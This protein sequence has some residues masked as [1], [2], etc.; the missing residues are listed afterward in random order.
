MEP[1]GLWIGRCS[2]SNSLRDGRVA[3]AIDVEDVQPA[4]IEYGMWSINCEAAPA[5]IATLGARWPQI[6]IMITAGSH[7]FLWSRAKAI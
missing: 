3:R 2:A 4:T 7:R 1:V 6:A 5:Y